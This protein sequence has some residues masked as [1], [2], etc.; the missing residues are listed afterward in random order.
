MDAAVANNSAPN[1]T[2]K[3][4]IARVLLDAYQGISGCCIH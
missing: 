4:D 3:L 1:A 2:Q